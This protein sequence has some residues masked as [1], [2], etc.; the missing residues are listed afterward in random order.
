MVAL[1]YLNGRSAFRSQKVIVPCYFV[2]LRAYQELSL[3]YFKHSTDE[4]KCCL[5]RR[6]RRE[7]GDQVTQEQRTLL[8]R[9]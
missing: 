8:E 6:W 3:P 1:T 4:L 7:V 9:P 2:R 5:G